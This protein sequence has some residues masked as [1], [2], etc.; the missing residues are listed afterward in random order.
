MSRRR[1]PQRH[2]I[3]PY[4]PD[5]PMA[6]NPALA[7]AVLE[8][9]DEQLRLGQPPETTA[10][11]R[12]L[13]AAGHTPEG[14]RQLIAHVVVREIFDVLKSGQPYNAARFTAALARLPA[15]PTDDDSETG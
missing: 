1:R 10:T 3:P 8:V 11:L 5:L 13:V 12:R 4:Q 9:V 15:L 2:H 14:A 7:A 6:A